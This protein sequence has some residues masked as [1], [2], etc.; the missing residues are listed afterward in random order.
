MTGVSQRCILL[1][2]SK[3]PAMNSEKDARVPLVICIL[4]QAQSSSTMQFKSP[5]YP[6]NNCQSVNQPINPNANQVNV[7]ALWRN[8][9]GDIF[10]HGLSWLTM[11]CWFS[12]YQY[13]MICKL[14]ANSKCNTNMEKQ[15]H[16][17]V[18]I[19]QTRHYH[20]KQPSTRGRAGRSAAGTGA[21]SRPQQILEIQKRSLS[22][23]FW[24]SKKKTQN[25]PPWR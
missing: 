12:E 18:H 20:A 2:D 15:K 9:D 25:I 6:L 21:R 8:F 1:S 16:K 7:Q 17:Q 24:K 3:A 14:F 13:I 11:A 5:E 10:G 22:C 4:V 23:D 19:A